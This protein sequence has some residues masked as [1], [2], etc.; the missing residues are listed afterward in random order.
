MEA[1]AAREA[2][3]DRPAGP[4]VGGSVQN[5][6]RGLLGEIYAGSGPAFLVYLFGRIAEALRRVGQVCIGVRN[7]SSTDETSPFSFEHVRARIEHALRE[8]EGR[9]IVI[10]I[11]NITSIFYGRD[12]GY[13]VERIELDSSLETIS[14]TAVRSKLRGGGS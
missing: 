6:A 9:F 13:A 3:R 2:D 11:P 10:Q 5:A 1:P 8:Y 7:T 14:P 12:V 4:V